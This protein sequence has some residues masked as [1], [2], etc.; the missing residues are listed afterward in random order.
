MA[1]CD[2]KTELWKFLTEREKYLR[3]FQLLSGMGTGGEQ[4][5]IVVTP[6]KRVR[7]GLLLFLL[8]HGCV[9]FHVSS[10]VEELAVHTE[11]EPA[12]LILCASQ[13]DQAQLI[14]KRSCEE[15]RVA[16]TGLRPSGESG[17]Q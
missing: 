10:P 2:D 3:D 8:C 9:V 5:G 17:V 14:E 7:K 6:A 11:R 1:G 4:E 15:L 13:S 16:K 12:M